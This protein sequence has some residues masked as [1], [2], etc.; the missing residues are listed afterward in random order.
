MI[1]SDDVI[2]F[3]RLVKCFNIA[4]DSGS[5]DLYLRQTVNDLV[6][7]LTKMQRSLG[8]VMAGNPFDVI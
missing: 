3:S 6:I 1:S 7:L 4:A 2:E 8:V 5:D